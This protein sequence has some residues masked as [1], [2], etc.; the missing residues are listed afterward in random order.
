VRCTRK[1]WL[2]ARYAYELSARAGQKRK[3]ETWELLSKMRYL[4][5]FSWVLQRWIPS[6][7]DI[8]KVRNS[9]EMRCHSNMFIGWS[10]YVTHW[11]WLDEYFEKGRLG[12]SPNHPLSF[13]RGK[14]CGYGISHL[15]VSKSLAVN[16]SAIC[17][18]SLS[19]VV[20]ELLILLHRSYSTLPVS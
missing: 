15:S 9:G 14:F 6:S 7:W 12:L 20:H 13:A 2:V 4:T 19:G 16:V 5:L 18:W 10:W 3:A 11:C 1:K 8:L 17:I